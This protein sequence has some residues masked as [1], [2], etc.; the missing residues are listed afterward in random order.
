MSTLPPL[1]T[2]E[3]SIGPTRFALDRRVCVAANRWGARRAVG[4]FFG[5]ISR[6]GDGMFWYALMAVLAVVGGQ[7]GLAAAAHM[8]VTGLVALLLYR[9]L[10]RWTHRPRPYRVC[11]GVIAHVPALDEFSFP[12]GHT[13]QAVSFTIVALAWYPQLAPLLLSF[14]VLVAASRVILGL[15]YPSDVLAAIVIGSGLGA[16][17]LWLLSLATK[18]A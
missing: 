2:P 13:L 6:L 1:H 10:K 4:M 8:A 3:L 15:H 5:A 11:P 12:S 17:S 18:L 14:T 16:S 7:H 9:L